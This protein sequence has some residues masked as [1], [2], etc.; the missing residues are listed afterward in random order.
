MSTAVVQQLRLLTPG[1]NAHQEEVT[2]PLHVYAIN[3][4]LGHN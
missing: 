3:Y 1:A 4:T 2:Y